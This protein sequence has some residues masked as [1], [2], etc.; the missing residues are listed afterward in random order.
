FGR[1]FTN[2]CM[3]S[4]Q[5]F[6]NTLLAAVRPVVQDSDFWYTLA[7]LFACKTR[8]FPRD[9][10]TEMEFLRERTVHAVQS[11]STPYSIPK[12]SLTRRYRRVATGGYFKAATMTRL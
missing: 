12:G 10:S 2:V 4:E 3:K 9:I 5:M 6:C 8:I 11:L 1:G 7:A